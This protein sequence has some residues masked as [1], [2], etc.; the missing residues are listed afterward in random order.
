MTLSAGDA[1]LLGGYGEAVQASQSAA[2]R[3]WGAGRLER[4]VGE[5]APALLARFRRQQ[6]TWRAA[7][8]AAWLAEY[9]TGDLL[10]AV[11]A[12]AGAMQRAWAAL[13]TW[14]SEAGHR[15]IAPWV[16][17]VWLADGSVAA[18]VQDDE[19]AS[20]VIADGRYLS[21]YTPK[22]VARLID[23]LPEAF[24]IA[25][26][27]WPGAKFQGRPIGNDLGASPWSDGGDAIPFG[28]VPDAP[29]TAPVSA[30]A[31]RRAPRVQQA[32]PK[33][34]ATLLAPPGGM[35]EDWREDFG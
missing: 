8:E 26:T 33:P 31:S 35:S 19:Q 14:A 25:K 18:F 12:K 13:D 32:A 9:L 27:T 17:E 21:V 34:P 5:A 30:N 1:G 15:P 10:G 16:W 3:T 29:P 11:E 4:L 20:K 24:K 2:E 6:E 22:E 28:D 23:V 7:L